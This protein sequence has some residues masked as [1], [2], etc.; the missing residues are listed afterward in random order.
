MKRSHAQNILNIF[1]IIELIKAIMFAGLAILIIVASNTFLSN[2]QLIQT[3]IQNAGFELYF[4]FGKM[5]VN[6]I[7]LVIEWKVLQDLVKD[8]TKT[9]PA[10][11]MTLVL[12]AFE[13]MNFITS[14]GKGVPANL[15]T[16]TFSIIVDMIV[17]YLIWGIK[18]H[19]QEKANS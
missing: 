4:S 6:A 1:S 5:I 13:I 19:A 16:V 7:L 8:E 2:N 3:E 10:W 12:I 11:T 17:L 9:G 15:G 18:K 14:I